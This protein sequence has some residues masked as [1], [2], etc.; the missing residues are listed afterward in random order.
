MTWQRRG[1]AA[2]TM[3]TCLHRKLR[4]S[5]GGEEEVDGGGGWGS[6]ML[7][8]GRAGGPVQCV[9]YNYIGEPHFGRVVYCR[10]CRVV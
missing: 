6:G 9:V 5:G 7:T 3:M 4:I 2:A 10:V 1:A 8:V